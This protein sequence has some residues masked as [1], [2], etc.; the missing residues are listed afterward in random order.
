MAEQLKVSRPSVREALIALEVEGTVEVRVGA[1]VYVL[2]LPQTR[3]VV[4]PAVA[5]GPFDVIR[6][7]YLIE[8]ECAALAATQASEVHLQRLK[9]AVVEMRQYR[10]H[11]PE[12]LAADRRFHHAIA[13]A[14]GNS[15]LLMVVQQLWVQRTG[16]LYMRLESHFVGDTVWAQ[17]LAEH[18]SLL[19][20]ITSR[21]PDA[22]RNAMRLH[23]K[24]AE[25]RFAASWKLHE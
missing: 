18:E 24:N 6:A 23:M 14:S 17:A 12:G 15:A 7:R 5:P 8:S 22:A 13:E 11:T 19:D 21:D 10:T 1:G 25:I 3:P 20:A 4:E 16:S 2:A 9:G